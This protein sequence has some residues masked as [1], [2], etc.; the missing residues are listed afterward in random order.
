MKNKITD[1]LLTGSNGVLAI[2]FGLI[3]IFFPG[4][5]LKALAI[6]FAISIIIGSIT[7]FISSMKIADDRHRI[8]EGI[9]GMLIGFFILFNPKLSATVFIAIVGIWAMVVG[10]VIIIPFIRRKENRSENLIPIILGTV[11][12]IAGVLIATNPF[13]GYRLIAILIGI[14]ALLYGLYS[15][16]RNTKRINKE[17]L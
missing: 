14:Y 12:F 9:I 2:L 16:I 7:L 5:T 13:E 3:A 6:Y 17:E 11:S 4:I 15:L 10:L 1:Y 8:I